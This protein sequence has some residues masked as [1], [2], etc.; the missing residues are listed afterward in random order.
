[1][2]DEEQKEIF[3]FN[4]NYWINK[5]NKSQKQVASDLGM[6]PTRFNTWCKGNSLPSVTIIQALCD[7]FGIRMT[8]LVDRQDFESGNLTK[9]DS[10]EISA[11]LSSTEE[12]LMQ[13]GLMFDGEPASQE[14]I[15][16]ILSAMK[17]G[18]EMAK[19]KNKEKYTPNKY[20]KD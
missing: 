8:Q 17:I 13:D 14:S 3:A 1:M 2:T 19:Q 15:D 12:L 18:M 11:I 10:R 9:K 16:S 20:K 7:Y 5:K 6:S 4:L